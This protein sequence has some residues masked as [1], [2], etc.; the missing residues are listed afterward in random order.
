MDSQF[1]QILDILINNLQSILPSSISELINIQLN[2]LRI[3]PPI[4]PQCS[5]LN[6]P[7]DQLNALSIISN[8]L[9]PKNQKNKYSYFFVTGLAGTGKSFL[10]NLI[11]ENLK[12]KDQIIYYW[13]QLV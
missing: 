1:N 13:P 2:S 7:E 12:K 11:V 8:I 9:G 5:A 6:L 4:L 10:I 3:N